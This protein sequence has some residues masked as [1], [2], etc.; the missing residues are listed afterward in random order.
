[1]AESEN[2]IPGEPLPVGRFEGRTEFQQGVRAA[3]AVAARAGWRELILSD[4]DFGDW[5]LGEK[6]VIE[7]LQA[8]ARNGRRMVLL[9]GDFQALVRSQ[10]R[11]VQ[12]RVRWDHILSARKVRGLAG[13]EVP[14]VLWSPHWV[15]QRL[16]PQRC[17]GVSG[18]E[19]ERLVL[20][21]ETLQEWI[22][23]RS[24]PGFPASVLGL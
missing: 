5:P 19:P 16:D 17:Y 23:N 2:P 20:Q 6:E 24:G 4:T 1:M 9:A 13:Q 21:R 22:D 15:L 18:S 11:F 3:L 12:W 10:P 14:S 8:W 7:S